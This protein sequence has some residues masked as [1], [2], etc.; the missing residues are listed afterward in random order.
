MRRAERT[1]NVQEVCGGRHDGEHAGIGTNASM[2]TGDR[3]PM[4][5]EQTMCRLIQTMEATSQ[6]ALS[7]S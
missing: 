1:H 6:G 4:V 7:L 3:G 2:A 5:L